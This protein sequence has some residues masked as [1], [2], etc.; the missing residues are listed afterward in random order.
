MPS[1]KSKKSNHTEP[2]IIRPSDIKGHASWL[3]V[4]KCYLKCQKVM[5]TKLAKLDLTTAQHE[6]LMNINHKPGISQQQISDR[7][8][9]VKS[10]TSAL[11]KKL[12]H[13]GLIERRKDPE[14][15]RVHHLHLTPAGEHKLQQSMSVQIEVVQAMTAVMS[16]EEIQINFEIMNRVYNSLD[17]IL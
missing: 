10:N 17:Q 15:A 2:H 1:P 14:D 6:L 16:D 4:V 3:S 13:R 5:N 8:L 7:L 12:L 9:V 11:L